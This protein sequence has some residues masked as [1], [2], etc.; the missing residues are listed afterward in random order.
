MKDSFKRT[1]DYLRIS[2]TDKCNLRCV[3]CMPSTGGPEKTRHLLSYEKILII[4]RTAVT[5]GV[6]KV[7]ITGGEPLAR[8]GIVPFIQELAAVKGL[9]DISLTTNGLLLEKYAD[10][11]SHAGLKRV[12]VSLDSLHADKYQKITR[13]GSLSGVMKG[14]KKAFHAGLIPIK[15]NNVPIRG[16]ND[17]EIET[18]A[19]LTLTT[20]FHIR[21][22]EFM[23]VGANTIWTAEKYIP[24]H[25]IKARVERIAPL[26]PVK[27]RRDGPARYYRFVKAQGVIGFISP[28][29][30][31]FCND[32]NRL[33]ITCDG[34]IRPC[35]FSS[36]MI[37]MKEAFTRHNPEQEI[38]K[39]LIKAI[40][41]KPRGHQ[42]HEDIHCQP[43]LTMAEIGG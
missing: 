1:I 30:H 14:I 10:D 22:I 39:L 34:K 18:F 42:I 28:L 4:V 36:H 15:I 41:D 31:H 8:P 17:D 33:R 9:A 5:L 25:E 7:R 13:G 20:P 24:T 21:F 37:D 12:N 38:K 27:L 43:P 3:Y 6:R 40:T 11:L 2:I 32:C 19:R 26:V 29:T 35:L 16:F 23:P